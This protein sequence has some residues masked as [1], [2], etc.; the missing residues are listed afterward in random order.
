MKAVKVSSNGPGGNGPNAQN[1]ATKKFEK[2]YK[3]LRAIAKAQLLPCVVF[4][5]SKANC[6]M[7]PAQLDPSIDF[8]NGEEK[9][10]IKKFIK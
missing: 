8:A 3:N 5:F 6:E 1:K 10:K 2:F 9:G 4:C 7:I